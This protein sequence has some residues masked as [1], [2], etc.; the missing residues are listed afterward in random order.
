MRNQRFKATLGRSLIRPSLVALFIMCTLLPFQRA[1]QVFAL[2]PRPLGAGDFYNYQGDA[3]FPFLSG[4]L[5]NVTIATTSYQTGYG[6]FF[7]AG[8]G[9]PNSSVN[10]NTARLQGYNAVTFAVGFSDTVDSHNDPAD[11]NESGQF[12]ITRD[13]Q[14]Y[15][16]INVAAGQPAQT[17]T[18]LIGGHSVIRFVATRTD[19]RNRDALLLLANPTAVLIGSSS[20]ASLSLAPTV[21]AGGSQV[22][23]VKTKPHAFV[24][25]IVTFPQGRPLMAGP[26]IASPKGQWSYAFRVPGGQSG[27][28]S[29]VIVAG[30]QVLQ[31][32]FNIQ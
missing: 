4:L 14:A 24:S 18:I 20:S 21:P 12:S 25:L 7:Y 13:G 31:G 32:N 5:Q 26:F 1:G 29:V 19:S 22:I 11:R 2:T 3:G 6:L 9:S 8:G 23:N 15:R 30:G 27:H 10:V 28:A 16:T 17:M